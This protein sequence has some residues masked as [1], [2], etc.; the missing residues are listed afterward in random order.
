MIDNLLTDRIFFLCWHTV[1]A[2]RTGKIIF[3]YPE[4]LEFQ[5]NSDLTETNWKNEL[6]KEKTTEIAKERPLT[7][8]FT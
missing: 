1:I 5:D 8:F 2:C 3:Y 6:A 7:F 4:E